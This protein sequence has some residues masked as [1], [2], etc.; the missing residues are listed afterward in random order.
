MKLQYLDELKKYLTE[1]KQVCD[2]ISKLNDKKNNLRESFKKWLNLNNL[3]EFSAED[4]EGTIWQLK[5]GVKNT[6]KLDK[7]QLKAKVGEEVFDLCCYSKEEE[8]FYC[9]PSKNSKR[10]IKPSAPH[11]D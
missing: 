2:E 9:N 11:G 6:T 4:N 5:K 3:N 7:S 8:F 1:Y 10:I